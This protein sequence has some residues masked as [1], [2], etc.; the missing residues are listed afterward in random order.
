MKPAP[1]V[2]SLLVNVYN[3]SKFYLFYLLFRWAI[4]FF[5]C[6]DNYR[7]KYNFILKKSTF[8]PLL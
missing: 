5:C 7:E 6:V 8:I 2:N 1:H 3:P 4:P